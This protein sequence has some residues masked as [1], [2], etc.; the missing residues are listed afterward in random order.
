MSSPD[1][2]CHPQ[3]CHEHSGGSPP[4]TLRPHTGAAAA[5]AAV[6]RTARC[7]R[8]PWEGMDGGGG[9]PAAAAVLAGSVGRV[10]VARLVAVP[11]RP[12]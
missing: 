10:H 4:L 8:R 7:R 2:P 11:R 6:G 5:A 12:V 3:H 1:G 9:C